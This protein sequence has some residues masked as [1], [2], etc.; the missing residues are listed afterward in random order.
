MK[1]EQIILDAYKNNDFP[2]LN[3]LMKNTHLENF[4]K[5]DELVNQAMLQI[6]SQL[7]DRCPQDKISENWTIEERAYLGAGLAIMKEATGHY[8]RWGIYI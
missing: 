4:K 6:A 3:E 2:K 8:K 7:K 5:E 1:E